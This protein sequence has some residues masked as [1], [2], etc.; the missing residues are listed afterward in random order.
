[1]TY[2]LQ[3]L[4]LSLCLL[5]LPLALSLEGENYGLE[6]MRNHRRDL[7]TCEEGVE[8]DK[9]FNEIFVYANVRYA[10][11]QD[12]Y[13]HSVGNRT[14]DYYISLSCF[15]R[16]EFTISRINQET[17]DTVWSIKN[18]NRQLNIIPNPEETIVHCIFGQSTTYYYMELDAKN[19]KILRIFR[20]LRKTYPFWWMYSTRFLTINGGNG[21]SGEMVLDFVHAN[22]YSR[23]ATVTITR[24]NVTTGIGTEH[25]ISS[26]GYPR[27]VLP[28]P[29]S[30]K[31]II[32]HDTD[33]AIHLTLLN[34]NTSTPTLERIFDYKCAGGSCNFNGRLSAT[35]DLGGLPYAYSLRQEIQSSTK[36]YFIFTK[37]HLNDPSASQTHISINNSPSQIQSITA[38]NNIVY[39]ILT[40]AKSPTGVASSM[41]LIYNGTEGDV[42]E[43]Y[44]ECLSNSQQKSCNVA[45]ITTSHFDSNSRTIYSISVA[46]VPMFFGTYQGKPMINKLSL[47]TLN[48]TKDWEHIGSYFPS[49]TESS[50][51]PL[52]TSFSLN[53]VSGQTILTPYTVSFVNET[54]VEAIREHYSINDFVKEVPKIEFK[55]NKNE[56]KTMNIPS[57]CSLSGKQDLTYSII[58]PSDSALLEFLKVNQTTG[59]ITVDTSDTCCTGTQGGFE[60]KNYTAVMRIDSYSFMDPVDIPME[61]DGSV[62]QEKPHN[63]TRPHTDP[64]THDIAPAVVASAI[65]ISAVVGSI[66]FVTPNSGLGGLWMIINQQQLLILLMMIGSSIH[67]DV[68]FFITRTKYVT[69]SFKELSLRSLDFTKIS[70]QLDSMHRNQTNEELKDLGYDSMCAIQMNIEIPIALILIFII[71]LLCI[72][73]WLI[74]LTLRKKFNKRTDGVYN[75]RPDRYLDSEQVNEEIGHF[76]NFEST[77]GRRKEGKK[78]TVWTRVKNWASFYLPIRFFTNVYMRIF[79]EAF[80]IVST[81]VLNELTNPEFSKASQSVS[82]ILSL[83]LL[84]LCISFIVFLFY[85]FWKHRNVDLSDKDDK[86]SRIYFEELFLDLKIGIGR[87]ENPL[88]MLRKFIFL[89]IIFCP[90]LGVISVFVILIL[91]QIAYIAQTVM[92]RK[93]NSLGFHLAS[94]LNEVFL[95]LFL[96]LFAVWRHQS[97]WSREGGFDKKLFVIYMIM[98]NTVGVII[99]QLTMGVGTIVEWFKKKKPVKDESPTAGSLRESNEEANEEAKEELNEEPNNIQNIPELILENPSDQTSKHSP[100]NLQ[101]H[102]SKLQ[103]QSPKYTIKHSPQH[104]QEQISEH[105]PTPAPVQL[106]SGPRPPPSSP[107]LPEIELSHKSEV[108]LF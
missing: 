22:G 14:G 30:N 18:S 50:L 56:T 38:Y 87:I 53:V 68:K 82:F 44:K 100:T 78:M 43:K 57:G 81:T 6:I 86:N 10:G 60:Q 98:M 24:T 2:R 79:L 7:R 88:S 101:K 4:L 73:A 96:V 108:P 42:F 83:I 67:P 104:V 63:N 92:I 12:R 74:P 59:K 64:H 72:I 45:Y 65:A 19:G 58:N 40:N 97:S 33:Q 55:I 75:Q 15:S 46:N 5:A 17:L 105:I 29:D 28:H 62:Y 31:T 27:Y 106:S 47:E 102:V 52:P 32:S 94:I 48:S 8:G 3:G 71:Q 34:F 54:H 37:I 41:L 95:G 1:M 39:I 77:V 11:C 69:F 16:N 26:C 89:C 23:S 66:A 61:I 51:D 103:E 107:N 76:E 91:I 80:F 85:Y 99:L 35:F 21:L 36:D 13:Y 20:H 84:F 93:F 90:G 25:I 70:N 49:R 9:Q